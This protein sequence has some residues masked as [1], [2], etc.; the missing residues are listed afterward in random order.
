MNSGYVTNC[1]FVNN[2]AYND[3]VSVF[4]MNDGVMTNCN[5]T[6]NT[7]MYGGAAYFGYS[8]SVNVVDCNFINNTAT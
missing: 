8:S 4:F 2:Y 5:F 7:A 3:G 1:N 6:G